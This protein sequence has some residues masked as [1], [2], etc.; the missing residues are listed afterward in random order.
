MKKFLIFLIIAIIPILSGCDVSTGVGIGFGGGWWGPGWGS[1]WGPFGGVNFFFTS[2]VKR[3]TLT[4]QDIVLV[5]NV[6]NNARNNGYVVTDTSTDDTI[7]FRAVKHIDNVAKTDIN[8]LP[9]FVHKDG[10]RF[11]TVSSSPT[12]DSYKIRA[13]VDLTNPNVMT[14]AK[15]MSNSNSMSSSK[16]TCR[17]DFPCQV[18]SANAQRQLNNGKTLEW[19]L[20]P[21][22]QNLIAVDFDVQKTEK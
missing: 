20:V 13:I 12:K 7:S 1:G 10:A 3:S 16:I 4:P 5:N 21:G 22:K 15:S 19:N 6:V 18:K 8:G 9:D 14:L 11:I 2:D 17:M